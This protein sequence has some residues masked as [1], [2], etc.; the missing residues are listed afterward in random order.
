[1]TILIPDTT[2]HSLNDPVKKKPSWEFITSRFS[3]FIAFGGGLGLSRYAPG[4]IG[5]LLAFPMY[6][7]FSHYLD[8]IIFL[9][10]I[11]LLFIL[12]I[13]VCSVTGRALGAHDHGGMVWD[14][15]VAFL[16]IL[17]FIPDNWLWQLAAFGLFRFFDIVKP[18]PIKYYDNKLRGGFGVMFD[19]LLAA[20]YTLLTLAVFKAFV[21]GDIYV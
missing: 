5:T 10:L 12:G 2:D 8:P 4:T 11:D 3:H 6:W 7:F 21:L 1:M 19:D 14:E 17:F 13:Y 20:F 15:T 9:L 16:L 18:Q